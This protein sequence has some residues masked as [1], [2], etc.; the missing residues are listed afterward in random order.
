MP[1]KSEIFV[2]LRMSVLWASATA[3]NTLRHGL[4]KVSV[5]AMPFERHAVRIKGIAHSIVV[6]KLLIVAPALADN[7]RA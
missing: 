3:I 7:G 2:R 1:A 5:G 6:G 4:A